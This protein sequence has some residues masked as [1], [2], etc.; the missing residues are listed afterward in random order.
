MPELDFSKLSDAEL[1]AI[2]SGKVQQ[3]PKLRAA[4]EQ[5]DLASMSDEELL[6]IAN[7][8][9][10]QAPK[11][12][13]SFDYGQAASDV[14]KGIT[15]VPRFLLGKNPITRN[16]FGF[17]D[18]SIADTGKDIIGGAGGGFGAVESI[19]GAPTRAAVSELQNKDGSLSSAAGEFGKQ[20]G[21]KVE[22]A[23]TGKEI[24][25]KMGA[26]QE[27][28]FRIPIGEQGI[29]VSPAS[30][31][32]LGYD[33]ILDPSA[34]IGGA[35]GKGTKYVGKSISKSVPL[36]EGADKM[37]EAAKRLG[38]KPTK[39]QL[40]DSQLV[41]KLEGSLI[42][43]PGSAGGLLTRA[44]NKKNYD[45][46]KKES[47]GLIGS[48]TGKSGKEIGDQA[49]AEID[50]VVQAK[51]SSASEIYEIF[52]NTLGDSAAN[53]KPILNKLKK[54][55]VEN[56]G[57]PDVLKEIS[58]WRSALVKTEKVMKKPTSTLSEFDFNILGEPA[59]KMTVKK[60]PE[61]TTINELKNFRES[62]GPLTK[63]PDP[64]KRKVANAL[65]G[66]ASDAR[67]QS[68]LAAG[69]DD[70]LIKAADAI[71]ADVASD[72]AS[73]NRRGF[74]VKGGVARSYNDY[75]DKNPA[76]GI[77]EK[78]VKLNDS[79]KLLELQKRFPEAFETLRAGKIDDLIKRSTLKENIN[80]NKM[81]KVL[82]NLSPEDS[83][84]LFGPN[85][86]AKVADIS[87]VLANTPPPVNPSGTAVLQW[88]RDII[89]PYRQAQSIGQS[90]LLKVI[91]S[92][93][94]IQKAG[95]FALPLGAAQSIGKTIPQEVFQLPGGQAQ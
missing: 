8:P 65:Y 32:G 86:K 92:G 9:V 23:P 2:A 48:V 55:S 1:E 18:K 30:V 77:V 71:Y 75:L 58:K 67:T 57:N 62:L 51:L 52:E 14:F 60:I 13:E 66:A 27:P 87:T 5:I 31:A 33:V 10:E 19:T 7:S 21:A 73:L 47:E 45:I 3:Q 79:E 41:E 80:P 81:V 37:L 90:A 44:K 78:L 89:N 40:Y 6:K 93:D 4:P 59:Q 11:A 88:V 53:I 24:A 39:S 70:S 36:K 83:F 15:A 38:I 42:Q 50:K 35:V 76:E 43:Q 72:V 54:L 16:L 82:N 68:L 69:A 22:L 34:L 12:K 74:K 56:K 49:L 85:A 26:S 91:T 94:K 28:M 17:E 64:V 20:F 25:T 29:D 46:I 61:V 84:I 63:S 95:K